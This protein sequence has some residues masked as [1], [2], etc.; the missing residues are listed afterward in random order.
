M[1]TSISLINILNNKGEFGGL[2]GTFIVIRAY[3]VDATPGF[4]RIILIISG[5]KKTPLVWGRLKC[6]CH[7]IKNIF[8]PIFFSC[9]IR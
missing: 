2:G 5:N 7:A 4:L 6:K 9:D 1:V 8:S 3:Y